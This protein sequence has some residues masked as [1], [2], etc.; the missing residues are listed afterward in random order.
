M[1]LEQILEY[2]K[3]INQVATILGASLLLCFAAWISLRLPFTPVPI[4]FT[5]QMVLF[6]S[7]LLGKRAPLAVGAYLLEGAMGLPVF[8]GGAS[9]IVHLLGP[10]GGYLFGYLA[11][12]YVVGRISAKTPV[13]A[14]GSMLLGNALIYLFGL[15]HL[16]T[17]VGW[18]NALKMGFYP[19][20]AL[21]LLKLL[22]AH[23]SLTC[24]N[25]FKKA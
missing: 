19:F 18:E 25:V 6:L 13:R 24:L 15:P 21:D 12:S 20:V 4:V 22:I 2:P 17:F 14:F 5:P 3:P 9:G 23:S 10:T 8:A 7:V 11:A 16:A 1:K